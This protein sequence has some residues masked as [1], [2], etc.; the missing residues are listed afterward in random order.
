MLIMAIEKNGKETE[1]DIKKYAK[2]C[3]YAITGKREDKNFI[4]YF[5]EKNK[6]GQPKKN[7]SK[8]E[9]LILRE[10]GN[11]IKEICKVLGVSRSTVYN[12]LGKDYPKK[13]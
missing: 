2:K 7:I 13:Q 11:S 4:S 6:V 1:N 9:I 8:E 12:Y 10:K 5:M 3:G